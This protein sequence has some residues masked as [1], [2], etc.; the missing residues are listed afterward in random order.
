MQKITPQKKAT[1]TVAEVTTD[2]IAR[3]RLCPWL[4]SR[5]FRP[6]RQWT[7]RWLGRGTLMR[8]FLTSGAI[9]PLALGMLEPPSAAL[10]I[11]FSRGAQR[12]LARLTG[13]TMG[14]VD[15]APVATTTD[16]HLTVAAGAGIEAGSVLHRHKGPMR[17]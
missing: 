10:L 5:P 9:T 17:T 1:E 8:H 15:I 4:A 11:T 7:I 12:R 2:L 16:H 3:F 13:A 14:A 6:G